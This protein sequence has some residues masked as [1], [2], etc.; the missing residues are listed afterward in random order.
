VTKCIRDRDFSWGVFDEFPSL[1]Q[2]FI[3]Q[4]I[5]KEYPS[6]SLF[7]PTNMPEPV[8]QPPINAVGNG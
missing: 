2:Q 7:K 4:I 1:R 8:E 3:T 5:K 6:L